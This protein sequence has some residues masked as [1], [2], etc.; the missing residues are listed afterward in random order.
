MRPS[1]ARRPENAH[2][3]GAAPAR[4][5]RPEPQRAPEQ[6]GLLALQR[7]AGNAAVVQLLHETAP[8]QLVAMR[9]PAGTVE[10]A[11]GTQPIE[12]MTITGGRGDY[13][14]KVRTQMALVSTRM[15][16]SS[17]NYGVQVLN[18]CES[19]RNY[20]N[21]KVHELEDQ[22]TGE[23]LAGQLVGAAL[24]AIG[25]QLT[26]RIANAAWKYVGDKVADFV[27]DK[28]KEGAR[29]AVGSGKAA[30][31][32]KASIDQITQGARDASTGAGVTAQTAFDTRLK[33]IYERCQE[34]QALAPEDEDLVGTFWDLDPAAIDQQIE[35][36]LGI[37]SAAS[38]AVAQV[39][40]YRSLVEQFEK[41]YI[42]RTATWEENFEMANQEMIGDW[43]LS[44]PGR[45][46]SEAAAASHERASSLGVTWQ[47]LAQAGRSYE[48][49]RK[50]G[51]ELPARGVYEQALAE[52]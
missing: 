16:G 2:T 7:A 13:F 30:S 19:F 33:P 27:K 52:R 14:D 24:N 20:A 46:R 45:A 32:L 25:G 48:E 49:A 9:E 11:S 50:L 28:I 10:G 8:Q 15:V 31:E 1:R 3:P 41:I 44:L 43:N 36:R 39:E 22:I 26:E 38:A 37:P 6:Q 35:Q 34:R 42:H 23:E 47:S 21:N 18:A 12:G 5:R 4:E 40:V 29:K 17:A 51:V